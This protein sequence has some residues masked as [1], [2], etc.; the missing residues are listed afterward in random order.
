MPFTPGMLSEESLHLVAADEAVLHVV[1]HY[2]AGLL[3]AL[4]L[5][6]QLHEVLVGGDDDDV[7]AAAQRALR[8]RADEVVR[9]EAGGL[10]RCDVE[11]LGH[12]LEVGDLFDERLVRF[13]AVR[14][15]VREHLVAERLSRCVERDGEVVG[16][17]FA[18]H[19]QDRVDEPED[20][21]RGESFRRGEPADRVER[22][23]ERVR[24]V[25][26]KKSLHRA[27]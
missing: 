1:V 11:G 13:L 25:D 21:V 20:R 24:P 23:E 18:H 2:D 9:L 12:A 22:A 8:E 27:V 4:L 26:Q 7:H 6:D 3:L 16:P 5:R 19:L 15:V 14:L 17:V 10:Q